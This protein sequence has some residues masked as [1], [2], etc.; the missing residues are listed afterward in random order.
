MWLLFA[1]S[2]PVLW[3]ISMHLD[4]YLVERYFRDANP[5]V[6]LLFTAITG[7]LMLP[8]IWAFAPQVVRLPASSCL[9]I[10]ASGFVFMAAFLPY[11]RALQDEEAS[12]VAPFF[13]MAP[14]FG[15][16]LGYLV[17]GERLTA[18]QT[19]GGAL[20]V[21]GTLL[22]SHRAGT[23]RREFKIRLVLLMLGCAF[24]LSLASLVFKFFAISAEFWSTLFWTFVGQAAFGIMI[25]SVPPYRQQL[26]E[27]LRTN[28][29]ALVSINAMNELVNLGG[30]LGTRYALV[31]A[32]LSLVQAVTSTTTLFVF[33]FGIVLS[34][35]FPQFAREE[36]GSRELA[37]KGIAACLIVI[38]VALVG[39]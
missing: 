31:L 19:A 35:L 27:L 29:R 12:V 28:A 7:A 34:L 20:V 11:F 24:L 3:A 10:T 23:A 39:R 4:K 26:A 22:L 25:L 17:L 37:T 21:G 15:Y 36:L 2:G 16:V 5:A 33:A 13:Q 1:L 6:L 8:A 9:V 18:V 14:V 32:P 38:G 30:S